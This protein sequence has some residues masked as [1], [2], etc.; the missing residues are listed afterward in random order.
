MYLNSFM[1]PGISCVISCVILTVVA[2]GLTFAQLLAQD[3][4]SPSSHMHSSCHSR[5]VTYLQNVQHA[6]HLGEDERLVAA[7]LQ[8][9]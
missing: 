5:P 9:P 1:C 8:S 3:P 4:S 2:I 7:G 6:G